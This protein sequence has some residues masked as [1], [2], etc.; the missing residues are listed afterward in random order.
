MSTG[1]RSFE[2]LGRIIKKTGKTIK[3]KLMLAS[4]SF[5]LSHKIAQRM[6]EKS[7]ILTLAIDDT[8]I[9]KIY[10]QFMIGSGRFFDIKIY[11]KIVAYRLISSVLTDG[12]YAIPIGCGFLFDKELLTGNEIVKSKI[13]FV[14]E[15]ILLAQRLFPEKEI[16]VAADG[17]FASVE[18]LKW[19][20]DNK[21][22][23]DLRM[24][25]NR[26][27]EYKGQFYKLN[28]IKRMRL[29]RG[30]MARSIRV[31]WHDLDLSITA[32]K[33]IDKHNKQTIVFIVST[34][35]GRPNQHVSAYKRR[36]P[37]EKK[38]RTTKQFL[39]LE[40]CFSTELETQENHVAAVFLAYAITQLEMKLRNH[41]TPEDAIRALKHKNLDFLM[42]RFCRLDAIFGDINA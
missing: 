31:K 39:G 3:K 18:F 15:F 40:E 42:N 25:S 30:W 29:G 38:Y 10:S 17:L 19:C 20:L 24:H 6:F 27:V 8:L 9:Q 11:R 12:R 7:K 26:K 21:F 5:S 2:G 28:E 37:I 13:D 35:K 14:K 41:D 1:K 22:E 33:R 36:W 4:N 23:A 32:E 16:H 34:Y